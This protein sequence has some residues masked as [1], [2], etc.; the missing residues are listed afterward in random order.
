MSFFVQTKFRS[1]CAFIV[2]IGH[3]HTLTSIMHEVKGESLCKIC[4]LKQNVPQHYYL[5]DTLDYSCSVVELK[6]SRTN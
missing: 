1:P 5:L 3:Y 6:L 4:H 2:T